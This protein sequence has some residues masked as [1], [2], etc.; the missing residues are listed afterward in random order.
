M[1][2]AGREDPTPVDVVLWRAPLDVPAAAQAAMAQTLTASER[3][4]AGSL[5]CE[6][7]RRRFVAGR[8]WLRRLLADQLD[9][10]PADVAL[11]TGEHGKPELTGGSGWEFNVSRSDGL[12]LYAVARGV[13]VGVDLERIRADWDIGAIVGRFF[14]AA[15]REAI[16]VLEPLRRREATF[17]CWARKEAYVKG[18]GCGLCLV[19]LDRFA[20]S[21]VPGRPVGLFGDVPSP[22]ELARWT[23][24]QVDAGPGF[25]AALA[26]ELPLGLTGAGLNLARVHQPRDLAWC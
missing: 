6:V 13:R 3:R 19:P 17:H 12:A 4:R 1:T 8:G 5:R 11:A 2:G 14:A 20:V 25:A 26:V 10:E 9:C 18:I 21:V 7:D 16:A 22:A 15:E 23:L 24:R